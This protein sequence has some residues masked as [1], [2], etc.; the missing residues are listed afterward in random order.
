MKDF[1]NKIKTYKAIPSE[2]AWEQL[3]LK[4][5]TKRLNN[6]KYWLIGFLCLNIVGAL[7][8][9]NFFLKDKTKPEKQVL[10]NIV[11]TPDDNSKPSIPYEK[12]AIELDS[13]NKELISEIKKL[14]LEYATNLIIQR[15]RHKNP[16]VIVSIDNQ[17]E[18]YR[19]KVSSFESKHIKANLPLYDS[20]TLTTEVPITTAEFSKSTEKV[21]NIKLS[22][23]PK[24]Q[25]L[26]VLTSVKI[27][28]L[29]NIRPNLI[30][31]NRNNFPT[32]K[33]LSN[34][35]LSLS[36]KPLFISIQ[37]N[38]SLK[39]SIQ[40]QLN[41]KF[42]LGLDI[43]FER[44]TERSDFRI[45]PDIK[46]KEF[47]TASHLF[48]RFKPISFRKITAY[49]DAGVGYKFSTESFR[50]NRIVDNEL[51]YFHASKSEQSINY[52]FALGAFYKLSPRLRM[53][54]SYETFQD[55]SFYLSAHYKL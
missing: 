37:K 5:K 1:R 34:W 33:M 25:N 20:K 4:K 41:R 49:V 51:E 22:N 50:R 44:F 16:D 28:E 35:Y 10:S 48:L 45:Y 40:Y 3:L 6:S 21:L 12:V 9:I 54:A 11:E 18:N 55:G 30:L 53:G 36:Y 17:N 52:N 26:P 24:D 15:K 47:Q 43:S 39:T 46:D 2:S 23:A 13:L 7:F 42:D 29:E 38:I 19:E 31:V 27:S 14:K 8:N 32:S